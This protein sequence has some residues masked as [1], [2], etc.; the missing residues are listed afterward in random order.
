MQNF[1]LHNH[2]LFSDGCHSVEEI[3]EEAKSLDLKQIGISDHLDFH[4]KKEWALYL[5][6]LPHYVSEVRRIGQREDI[7]VLLG[8]EV[9]I[10]TNIEET[11]QC[12][13]VK[14]LYGFDFFIGSFHPF[15][16]DTDHLIM[17]SQYPT[18]ES[19]AQEHKKYWENMCRL[20]E[21]E[22]FDIIGHMDII[23]M[24]GVKT[25]DLLQPEIIN[26]L[27]IVKKTGKIIEVNT[28]G[29]DE[30]AALE[31]C[32]SPSIIKKCIEMQI[33]LIISSD[34]HD[35]FSITRNFEQAEELINKLSRE[36]YPQTIATHPIGCTKLLQQLLLRPVHSY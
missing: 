23:K 6:K 13:K 18:I 30:P 34:S 1:S 3:V 11:I 17:R 26:F 22:T 28:S 7:Q 19:M 27:K 2:S 16:D 4:T 9:D 33:P 24:C 31:P 15:P 29:Y 32:P 8:A 10:P 25:E 21:N 12:R 20:A 14:Y 35:K 5:E 36:M